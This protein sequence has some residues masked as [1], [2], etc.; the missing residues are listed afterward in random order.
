[1]RTTTR[2]PAKSNAAVASTTNRKGPVTKRLSRTP[3][4]SLPRKGGGDF[5]A[6]VSTFPPPP[7]RGRVGVGGIGRTKFET[8]RLL[9][10][11][12][13]DGVEDR[14]HLRELL[15]EALV[16]RQHAGAERLL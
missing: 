6:T 4:P 14:L 2:S 16:Q 11:R 7:L 5:I 8:K 1:M 9:R 12:R 15:A 3:H 13:L 10:P